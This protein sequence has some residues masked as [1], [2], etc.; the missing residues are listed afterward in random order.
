MVGMAAV[1]MA[2]CEYYMAAR[3][4][5]ARWGGDTPAVEVCRCVEVWRC[6]GVEGWRGAGVEG[7]RGAQVNRVRQLK[8]ATPQGCNTSRLQR[9]AI[10]RCAACGTA[11]HD[12]RRHPP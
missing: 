11:H 10:L 5:G 3:W 2:A 4:R 1:G 6:G 7:R 8:A 9:R 12:R